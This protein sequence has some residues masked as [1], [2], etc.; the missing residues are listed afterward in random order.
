[1]GELVA[2]VKHLS[3]ETAAP[4]PILGSVTQE[5]VRLPW[6]GRAYSITRPSDIDGLLDLAAD[7]PEQHL[8]Y[9]AELWPSGIALADGIE[10][11]PELVRGQRVFELG[12]GLGVTA[13]AA[14]RAGALLTVSDYAEAALDLCQVNC[15]ANAAA[16]PRMIA[17]NWRNRDEIATLASSG[18][19]PVV[20]AADVLYE[21]RDIGPLIDVIRQLL[22]PGGVFWVAEPGRPVAAEFLSRADDLGWQRKSQ[23]HPGPWPDAADEGVVVGLHELRLPG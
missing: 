5:T 16:V 22:A 13:I 20:L 4:R 15:R 12:C 18:Q 11:N 8:P 9:W 14:I 17:M 21:R 10:R 19:V 2:E 7:D 1:M 23:R 3:V 6:S